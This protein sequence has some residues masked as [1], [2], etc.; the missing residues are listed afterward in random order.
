[1]PNFPTVQAAHDWCANAFPEVTHAISP[2][3]TP[4]VNTQ[5]HWSLDMDW[6]TVGKW[7]AIVAIAYTV[8]RVGITT[9]WSDLVYVWNKI[10][11]TN[12]TT[13]TTTTAVA[14]A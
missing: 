3:V 10:R 6:F 5:T 8:G 1:M 4:V 9:L 12:T 11:G 7:A 13:T 14:A 2:V